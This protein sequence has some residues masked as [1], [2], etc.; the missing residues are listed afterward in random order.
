MDLFIGYIV[1]AGCKDNLMLIQITGT[2]VKFIASKYI[3]E[4][5][6][7]MS[8]LRYI[9]FISISQHLESKVKIQNDP[10]TNHNYY[11]K[12]CTLKRL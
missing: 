4:S 10:K 5:F 12:L 8:L 9:S 11:W 6:I 2:S 1:L 3:Q 7:N